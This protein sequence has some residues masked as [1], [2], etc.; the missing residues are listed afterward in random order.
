MRN[1]NIP[2]AELYSCLPYKW[3][4]FK[5]PD[6]NL[7]IQFFMVRPFIY[8]ISVSRDLANY[9]WLIRLRLWDILEVLWLG[10]EEEYMRMIK[11]SHFS[12]EF[13]WLQQKF[14]RRIL[15]LIDTNIDNFY[16]NE[17]ILEK[18]RTKADIIFADFK[19]N[20]EINI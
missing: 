7:P 12:W 19:A 15:D 1:F 6:H 9:I 20:N 8:P 17:L 5:K 18:I 16:R 10:T 3:E 14:N 2:V 13:C 4:I 11:I